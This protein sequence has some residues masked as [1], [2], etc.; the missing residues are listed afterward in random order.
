M[1]SLP[2]SIIPWFWYLGAPDSSVT[3]RSETNTTRHLLLLLLAAGARR[4]SLSELSGYL[5]LAFLLCLG[6]QHVAP[7]VPFES[8]IWWDFL[9]KLK[10]D[11]QPRTL[12]SREGKRTPHTKCQLAQAS[13][14]SSHGSSCWKTLQQPEKAGHSMGHFSYPEALIPFSN[15]HGQRWCWG[16]H[17]V[18]ANA[19]LQICI[20]FCFGLAHTSLAFAF[21]GCLSDWGWRPGPMQLCHLPQWSQYFTRASSDRDWMLELHAPAFTEINPHM[22]Y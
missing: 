3:S 6:A 11:L 15:I 17:P 4:S 18:T 8:E 2:T 13:L 22:Q 9:V 20:S 1:I 21:W 14:F 12:R 10:A 16:L 7:Y 5:H 19:F